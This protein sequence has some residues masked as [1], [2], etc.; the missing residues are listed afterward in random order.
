MDYEKEDD[1]VGMDMARKFLQM[2]MTRAKRYAN[3]K[4]GRKYPPNGKSSGGVLDG[5]G[6]GW[7]GSEGWKEKEEASR[8]FREVWEK[9][10]TSKGY[11]VKKTEF[12]KKQ[13]EWDKQKKAKSR[14][15]AKK[16][17]WEG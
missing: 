16:D 5:D 15:G 14:K 9:A 7:K 6:D 10:R 3:H 8:V 12:L 17:E 13:K 1:F 4:G 11:L 2:G